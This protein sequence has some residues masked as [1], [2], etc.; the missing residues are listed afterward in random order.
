[1][2]K[3]EL[4]PYE[5]RIIDAI[6]QSICDAEYERILQSLAEDDETEADEIGLKI[7]LEIDQE[8]LDAMDEASERCKK[9]CEE[10]LIKE[11]EE[12]SFDH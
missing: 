7:E 5:A 9:R 6:C 1:M 12:S 8:A 3:K 11:R 4:S 10:A 2:I